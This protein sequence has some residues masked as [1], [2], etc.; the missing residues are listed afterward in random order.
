MLSIMNPR[1]YEEMVAEY[2]RRK[3]YSVE[4]TCYTN[5]Y[6]VDCFASRDGERI[7]VQ[8]KMYGHGMRSVNRKMMMELRGAMHFFD[9]NRAALVTNGLVHSDAWVVAAK[10]GI[11]VIELEALTGPYPRDT[12]DDRSFEG[13]WTGHIMPLAGQTLTRSSGKSNTILEVDW[14]GIK[15]I[16]SNGRIQ[17]IP[18]EIFRFAVN[19]LREHGNVKKALINDEFPGRASAGICLILCQVPSIEYDSASSSL[20]WRSP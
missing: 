17:K 4:L 3:G 13:I 12:E 10:L 16:T 20:V 15:R 6:G 18:I 7:A 1:Q 8:A 19:Q 11:E 14:S 2:F 5:D 9:C